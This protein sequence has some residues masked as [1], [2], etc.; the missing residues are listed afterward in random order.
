MAC[1]LSCLWREEA[2]AG[3]VC[4]EEEQGRARVWEEVGQCGEGGYGGWGVVSRVFGECFMHPKTHTNHA[5][6]APA[7]TATYYARLAPVFAY[8]SESSASDPHRRFFSSRRDS[9]ALYG[10]HDDYRASV[11]GHGFR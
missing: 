8:S 4:A 10:W 11:D 3:A 7:L 9:N 2:A 1:F 5:D 6:L